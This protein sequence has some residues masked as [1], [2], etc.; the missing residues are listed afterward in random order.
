MTDSELCTDPDPTPKPRSGHLTI[1]T[2]PL[3]LTH[4]VLTFCHPKDVASFS[5]T[6]RLANQLSQ[7]EYLW[8]QLWFSYPFDDPQAVLEQRRTLNLSKTS[9]ADVPPDGY[10]WKEEFSRR[11]SAERVASMKQADLSGLSLKD[12]QDALQLLVSVVKSLPALANE[13]DRGVFANRRVSGNVQWLERI[14]RKSKL[15]A[16]DSANPTEISQYQAHLRSCVGDI[17]WLD[18]TRQQMS[19]KRNRSR[20]FVYDLRN[21]GPD[22]EYG[23]FRQNRT[24]NWLHAEHLINVVLGNLRDLPSHLIHAR[25]LSTLESF[26]PYSAPGG[27]SPKDWAGIEGRHSLLPIQ[28]FFDHRFRNLEKICMFYGL[29]VRPTPLDY[30][31][32]IK[33]IFGTH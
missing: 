7:D 33:R 9:Q 6:C 21:Y 32:E 17:Q 22:N 14:L 8:R 16:P 26:R 20:A 31:P 23:P 3:E 24:V 19:D 13:G 30:L 4:R 12:K 15:I 18:R 10:R 5:R 28:H 27:Y 11:M 2:I 25:P 29:S 1:F